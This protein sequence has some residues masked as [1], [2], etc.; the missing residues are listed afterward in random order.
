MTILKFDDR[1]V[2]TFNLGEAGRI[3]DRVLEKFNIIKTNFGFDPAEQF[4]MA[5]SDKYKFYF[6]RDSFGCVTKLEILKKMR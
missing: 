5:E 6:S 3:R 2:L 1:Y 4:N